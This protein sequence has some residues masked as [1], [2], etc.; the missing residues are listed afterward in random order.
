MI[1]LLQSPFVNAVKSTIER[2]ITTTVE[3]CEKYNINVP[4]SVIETCIATATYSLSMFADNYIGLI[5]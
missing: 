1:F 5:V 2:M 3:T 4:N